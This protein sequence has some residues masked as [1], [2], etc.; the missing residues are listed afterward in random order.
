MGK[1]D[2]Y[3]IVT[4]KIIEKLEN[5]IIP[6]K[7]PWN[8][9]GVATRWLVNKPY[10]GFNAMMLEPGGEY[11]SKKQILEAGGRIKKE[12]MRFGH[13]VVYWHWYK[14]KEEGQENIPDEQAS[15]KKMA[16]PF[17]STVWE[18][19]TQCEN[20]KS[21]F[22]EVEGLDFNP[23]E[24]AETLIR[25]YKDIP[26]MKTGKDGAYY[27]PAFDFISMPEVE[28]FNS[29]EE[30]YSTLFHELIHSTGHSKRLCREGI[31]D[32][33][34]FGSDKYAK[35]ELVAEM[36]SSMLCAMVGIDNTTIDNAAS[37][38][39]GWLQKLKG[40]KKFIFSASSQAQQGVDYMLD[41]THE[42]QKA[43]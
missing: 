11:A 12:E 10:R 32:I 36:G 35:E 17:Y 18:I 31:T 2:V 30:Y 15:F 1:K 13:I 7:K 41:I 14:V 16:K 8:G 4:E 24:E 25:K 39:H 6:W 33:A 3:E 28:D 27:V 23:I 34:K 26:K 20:M 37:Y 19:N 42:E 29:S 38:I 5:G 9:K 40:D 21:K 43:I 22:E